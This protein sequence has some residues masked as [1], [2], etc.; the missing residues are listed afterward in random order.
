MKKKTM[1]L[2]V[3]FEIDYTEGDES[4][5]EAIKPYLRE[6]IKDRCL[7]AWQYAAE[8]KNVSFYDQERSVRIALLKNV[9]E[10]YN[11]G[12]LTPREYEA[13]VHEINSRK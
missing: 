2:V 9:L 10:N 8:V 4:D 7:N 3:N 6:M 13:K 11:M 5:F 1:T 12:L